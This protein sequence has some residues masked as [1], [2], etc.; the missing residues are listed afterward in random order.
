MSL[1]RFIQD[2]L[3]DAQLDAINN[4]VNGYQNYY[5]ASADYTTTDSNTVIEYASGS[6]TVT[7]HTPTGNKL[8]YVTNSGTGII[9]VNGDGFSEVVYM[10][11][12]FELF[13]NGTNWIL[14]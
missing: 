3:T 11:E 2:K 13:F 10:N 12:S 4:A 1:R 8:L 6:Y 7:L 14:L 9:S 5:L